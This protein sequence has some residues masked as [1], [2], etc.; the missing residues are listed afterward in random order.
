[1]QHSSVPPPHRLARPRIPSYVSAPASHVPAGASARFPFALALGALGVV[2]GDIGTNPLFALGDAF[3]GEHRV[4]TDTPAVLGVLSLIFWALTLV[5]SVKYL[6]FVMRAA[7][8]GEGG[9][10]ALLGLIPLERR[11]R[12]L[13]LA[14]LFGAGLLYG[15]GVITPAISVLSA[16]EGLKAVAPSLTTNWTVGITIAILAAL[17]MVQ[18]HG[19]ERIGF[20]FGPV[21]VVW[22]IALGALGAR[23]IVHAPVV[24]TALNPL[25]AA[26]F[27]L[28][29]PHAAFATLGAIV[30]CVAG[31]E[32]LYADMG[33]FGRRP[34]ALAWYGVVLPAL[35]LNYFGQG[36][37][38]LR[39]GVPQPTVFYALV[40]RALLVPMIVLSTT[41]TVIASQALISGAYS[42]TQQAVQLGFAPRVT[43]VHT[44]A[45][46]MGQ[47]YVPEI[48]RAL[49]VACIALVATF[50]TS[51][52]LAAAYGL[53]VM[54]TMTITTVA[55][56]VLLTRA[57]RWPRYTA[58]P[59]CA[60][61][62]AIDVMFLLGNLRKFFDGGWIPF[63]MGVGVFVLFT[64][65]MGGRRRLGAHLASVMLPLPLFLEDVAN[66]KP[67]RVR[68]TAVFLTA[69][70]GGVPVLLLHHFK[71]NQ[72]L[73]EAVVLLTV[74]SAQT[75]YVKPAERLTLEELGLGFY[76][77]VGRFG[78]M[79]TPSVPDLLRAAADK[80]LTVDLART[81]YYL[82][83]ETILAGKARGM[84]RWRK[85]LFAF[86]SRNARSA[87][88]YFGIPPNRV[89]EL[90]MQVEL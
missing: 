38:L 23:Q 84:R 88:E 35:V 17:F 49:T 34:I 89:V 27:F 14:V 16:V 41:A 72:V 58:L 75:P 6:T 15:D 31:G 53:S 47:I 73:H 26:R 9:I 67:P 76:W 87:T 24:L 51:A 63:T 48:N 22:F 68:G 71:H 66:V 12:V 52:S 29:R 82:G 36:A 83:R 25:H 64:T 30:L 39:G 42:L 44:S 37:F 8:D 11:A 79:E 1:M 54:G 65:W 19:T 20:V 32:A 7:N 13:V 56:F 4:A 18:R 33:H 77:L 50:K 59:L 57:W 86:V 21:M 43:I 10:L 40:P 78:Y 80:G 2:Y 28:Q 85:V 81:T 5:V 46:H 74:Q 60:L 55:Y 3:T 69:N 62:L 70:R 61:F 90:G 45:G